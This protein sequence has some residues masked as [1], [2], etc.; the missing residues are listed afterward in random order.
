VKSTEGARG[1][2]LYIVIPALNEEGTIEQ[3][4]SVVTEASAD[5]PSEIIVVNDHSTDRTGEIVDA[6]AAGRGNVRRVDNPGPGG[7]RNALRVGYEAAGDGVIVTMM[8]DLCDDP[9]TL[10]PMYEM[11]VDSYDVVCGSRYMPGGGKENEENWLKG[12]LSR[13]VGLSLRRLAGIPTHDVTN[14]FKMYRGDLLKSTTIEETGFASSMELT[15]KA[16]LKG[17]RIGEVPT[18][19]RGRTA[20]KSKFSMIK[21]IRPYIR[22][23]IL[24]LVLRKHRF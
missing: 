16:Y 4:L 14:A 15:V 6:F 22:W 8:A 13:W 24:I 17:A 18:I 9:A 21:G 7:F 20:G 12:L 11:I 19:W 2:K 5:I 10:V 23:Y 1:P 3:T